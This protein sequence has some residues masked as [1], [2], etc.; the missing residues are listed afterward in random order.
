MRPLETPG[1]PCGPV[2]P[3]GPLG[4]GHPCNLVWDKYALAD[5][6]Y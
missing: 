3:V 6:I 4:P 2:G 1:G 5:S